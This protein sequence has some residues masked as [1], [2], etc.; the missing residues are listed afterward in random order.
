MHWHIYF[1]HM[2]P[3][4]GRGTTDDRD[5]VMGMGEKQIYHEDLKFER[6]EQSANQTM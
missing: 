5:V 4:G 1:V 2:R 6:F 3:R